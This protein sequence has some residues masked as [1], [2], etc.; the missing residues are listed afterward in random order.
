MANLNQE[1]L[2]GTAPSAQRPTQ[3]DDTSKSKRKRQRK[4]DAKRAAREAA[5]VAQES[6]PTSYPTPV[7][8]E[9]GP[10]SP[11]LTR[12]ATQSS[13]PLSTPTPNA[14]TGHQSSPADVSPAQPST[15][16][17][18]SKADYSQF[19]L[20][21]Q[22]QYGVKCVEAA[23]LQSQVRGLQG[24]NA[25]LHSQLATLR[26]EMSRLRSEQ[27]SVDDA[28]AQALDVSRKK[29]KDTADHRRYYEK[30]LGEACGFATALV[31]QDTGCELPPP[32]QDNISKWVGALPDQVKTKVGGR[33][34]LNISTQKQ[35]TLGRIRTVSQQHAKSASTRATT[36]RTAQA[37]GN[38]SK[39]ALPKPKNQGKG[40][41]SGPQSL[42]QLDS[43]EQSSQP[44]ADAGTDQD[45]A[46][47]TK[48][49]ADQKASHTRA[50]S[51]APVDVPNES[52]PQPSQRQQ[53]IVI[54]STPVGPPSS[55]D[56][57]QSIDD[58]LPEGEDVPME[59]GEAASEGQRECF[60][61][62][63][64][65]K[66]KAS[67]E[68]ARKLSKNA[69]STLD[70]AN[71]NANG[72]AAASNVTRSGPTDVATTGNRRTPADSS[73]A[74]RSQSSSDGDLQQDAE[75]TAGSHGRQ[76][77]ERRADKAVASSKSTRD[78]TSSK[79]NQHQDS[80]TIDL[81]TN[82]PEAQPAVQSKQ[83]TQPA[84]TIK[85]STSEQQ[86]K[87]EQ[88]RPAAQ[89]QAPEASQPKQVGLA[90]K[91]SAAAE[92][93]V[94]MRNSS[95]SAQ[96]PKRKAP[97]QSPPTSQPKPAKKP[98]INKNQDIAALLQSQQK[99]SNPP[100]SQ[101]EVS[102]PE[103]PPVTTPNQGPSKWGETLDRMAREPPL[104]PRK[105]FLN[106][107]EV[108]E[109]RP[110]VT[111]PQSNKSQHPAA[112]ANQDS[113]RSTGSTVYAYEPNVQ[114]LEEAETR[115]STELRKRTQRQLENLGASPPPAAGSKGP[116]KSVIDLTA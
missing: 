54:P 85:P 109:R 71:A 42:G 84:Q 64:R 86:N 1:P 79:V 93:L 50:R 56:S 12:T 39:T 74:A 70:Q 115:A 45:P 10:S 14:A 32:L 62:S 96:P 58:V 17:R 67:K 46:D 34:W 25:D 38:A 98:K 27:A 75:P 2:T 23:D 108:R 87:T 53:K 7:K 20:L 26:N 5:Q 63:E 101:S 72:V 106:P 15:G 107:Q 114:E 33:N 76:E 51:A 8:T 30:K 66:W 3:A 92:R 97:N 60:K 73:V 31:A 11:L 13:V 81:T 88:G 59:N 37:D 44:V 110:P 104:N 9:E 49:L 43:C 100:A 6:H 102:D 78:R 57:F 24:E 111:P 89:T 16:G 112:T 52:T 83:Q 4:Q 90:R 47:G 19:Y 77:P 82:A 40:G 36:S 65:Q 48:A 29:Q 41:E 61:D 113:V 18:V 55:Q 95:R 116:K 94:Q 22:R 103:P 69:A 105:R 91:R 80:E 28:A 21:L 35:R 99:R 68:K